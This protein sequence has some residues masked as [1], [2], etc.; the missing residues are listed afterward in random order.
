MGCGLCLTGLKIHV[1]IKF[2][3]K[4]PRYDLEYLR[5]ASRAK[6]R[7]NIPEFRMIH[8]SIEFPLKYPRYDME[9]LGHVNRATIR[10]NVP[11]FR[12]RHVFIEFY[13][14]YPRFKLNILLKHHQGITN[15]I[16]KACHSIVSA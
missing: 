1:P 12:M 8:V 14:K 5:D 16:A 7:Q 4:F 13:L 10:Q 15:E 6:I 11:E 2:H 9:S 3:I